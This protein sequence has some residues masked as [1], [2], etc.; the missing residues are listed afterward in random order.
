MNDNQQIPGIETS[1]YSPGNDNNPDGKYVTYELWEDK[2]PEK[3]I[4]GQKIENA[5]QQTFSK[6]Q[7]E[8]AI[9]VW[10]NKAKKR[11]LKQAMITIQA[12]IGKGAEFLY[13]YTNGC[14]EVPPNARFYVK[15]PIFDKN[16]VT[17]KLT[18]NP[19]KSMIYQSPLNSPTIIEE[20]VN[21]GKLL[22]HFFDGEFFKLFKEYSVNKDDD[23]IFISHFIID[24]SKLKNKN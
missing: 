6:E 5:G 4:A 12:D 18:E 19:G 17:V 3:V 1:Y 22:A 15:K 20:I 8:T 14:K 11:H 2:H 24:N 16:I 9:P 23:P 10:K 21:F 13:G 7:L